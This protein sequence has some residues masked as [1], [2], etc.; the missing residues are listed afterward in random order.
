MCVCVHVCMYVDADGDRGDV[1]RVSCVFVCVCVC[2]HKYAGKIFMVGM[3]A[4]IS[5]R[6]EFSG[7]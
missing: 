1:A 5:M 2:M 4:C 3:Y 7:M 6:G